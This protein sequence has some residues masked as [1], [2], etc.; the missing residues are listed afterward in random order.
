MQVAGIVE[1][2]VELDEEGNLR[3]V[4]VAPPQCPLD[5]AVAEPEGR[6]SEAVGNRWI[7]GVVVTLVVV[8]GQQLKLEDVQHPGPK[9][10][11]QPLIVGYVLEEG[12]NYF[13]SLVKQ[14]AKNGMGIGYNN[15]CF[16]KM[17][18]NIKM[19]SLYPKNCGG[20]IIFSKSIFPV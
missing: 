20:T 18:S 2:L 8:F 19:Y 14:P 13:A 16:Q 15:H 11:G 5:E 4:F 10:N 1:F 6:R 9:N 12:A 17:V 3:E 7:D